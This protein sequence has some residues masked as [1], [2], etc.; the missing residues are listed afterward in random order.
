MIRKAPQRGDN[1]DFSRI[2][3]HC[4]GEGGHSRQRKQL[5]KCEPEGGRV[6]RQPL[7]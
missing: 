3:W 7:S 6:Y 1:S 4:P 5:Q 2:A